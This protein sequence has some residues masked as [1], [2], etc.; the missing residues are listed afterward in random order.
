[1]RLSGTGCVATCIV[2]GMAARSTSAIGGGA[3]IAC[4][5]RTSTCWR[6]PFW[7]R[8]RSTGPPIKAGKRNLAV[9]IMS[10][11]TDTII[12]I[13]PQRGSK[14]FPQET[15]QTGRPR[16]VCTGIQ[17]CWLLMLDSLESH[18]NTVSFGFPRTF[19]YQSRLLDA[20]S[21]AKN[22]NGRCVAP[23]CTYRL[24]LLLALFMSGHSAFV[25]LDFSA[26]SFT[27]PSNQC[28]CAG[29]S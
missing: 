15:W 4:L 23:L 8:L 27:V 7:D 21:Y 10:A 14:A 24:N 6:F 22:T 3:F 17:R 1:M 11:C 18:R 5:L 25:V 9:P 19:P 26:H 29:Y 12:G 13:P 2:P 20:D 16:R 28:V